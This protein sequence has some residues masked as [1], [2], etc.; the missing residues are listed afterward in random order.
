VLPVGKTC[1]VEVGYQFCGNEWDMLLDQLDELIKI[2][3]WNFM[4][5]QFARCYDRLSHFGGSTLEKAM[6]QAGGQA[7]PD[8]CFDV[9][10]ELPLDDINASERLLSDHVAE[11]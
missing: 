7:S 5:R 1:L 2:A 11:L 10:E 3:T 8:I 4:A 9:V 6:N